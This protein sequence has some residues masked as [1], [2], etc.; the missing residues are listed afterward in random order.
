MWPPSVTCSVFSLSL[1]T[2]HPWSL[3]NKI[4]RFLICPSISFPWLDLT[5]PDSM[6]I[7]CLNKYQTKSYLALF[8]NWLTRVLPCLGNKASTGLPAGRR[9][10]FLS[11]VTFPSF[12]CLHDRRAAC[13]IR[14]FNLSSTERATLWCDTSQRQE[15][16]REPSP[17]TRYWFNIKTWGRSENPIKVVEF[18]LLLFS[19]LYNVTGTTSP[20]AEM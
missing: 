18:F 8:I 20:S 19:F 14:A 9:L 11:H 6:E 4:D 12:S 5:W 2:P 17:R 16:Q 10:S 3:S 7:L 15:R 1:V 13:Q